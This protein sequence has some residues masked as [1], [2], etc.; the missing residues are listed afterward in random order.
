VRAHVL[1]DTSLADLITDISYKWTAGGGWLYTWGSG[2]YGQLAQ[3]KRVV[4]FTPELC[5][6]F[7]E[8]LCSHHK[9]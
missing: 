9:G 7:L 8:A 4:L 3:G 1:L 6:Y 5:E 2:Y